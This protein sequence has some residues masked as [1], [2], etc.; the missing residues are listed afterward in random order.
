MR[1]ESLYRR[2]SPDVLP[3]AVVGTAAGAI[4]PGAVR[5][6]VVVRQTININNSMIDQQS[7]DTFIQKHAPRIARILAEGVNESSDLAAALRR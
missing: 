5:Q 2:I 6:A 4:A 3:D 7:G 1:R